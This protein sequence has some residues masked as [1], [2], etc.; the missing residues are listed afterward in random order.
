VTEW[1]RRI[2]A[3]GELIFENAELA[4]VIERLRERVDE[5]EAEVE[6][7][8]AVLKLDSQ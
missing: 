4:E 1:T 3:D 8:K 2:T 7:V 5:F 6:T